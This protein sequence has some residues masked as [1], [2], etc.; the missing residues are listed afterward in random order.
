MPQRDTPETD[1]AGSTTPVLMSPEEAAD[2][3]KWLATPPWPGDP[4]LWPGGGDSPHR[5]GRIRRL[6]LQ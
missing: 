6:W 3:D 5:P 1:Q 4:L 2:L